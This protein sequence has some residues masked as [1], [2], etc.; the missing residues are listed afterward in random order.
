MNPCYFTICTLNPKLFSG[1]YKGFG[2][3]WHPSLARRY[4]AHLAIHCSAR[5][6][7]S[8]R[9][10]LWVHVTPETTL[11]MSISTLSSTR[12]AAGKGF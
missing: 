10:S 2:A 8:S 12:F 7:E 3:I 1:V 11:E 4:L 9:V 5:Y 6:D